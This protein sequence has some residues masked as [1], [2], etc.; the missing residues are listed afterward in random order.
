MSMGDKQVLQRLVER[1]RAEK[2]RLEAEGV[3]M[4]DVLEAVAF[5]LYSD[6]PEDGAPMSQD[7]L[8]CV[9][10]WAWHPQRLVYGVG[11][12][13]CGAATDPT[14]AARLY[15]VLVEL[16][17]PEPARQAYADADALMRDNMDDDG[18]MPPT[19]VISF[20]PDVI[21]R[22]DR[23][24]DYQAHFAADW[25]R[26][27]AF[28][29]ID[30]GRDNYL[31]L[32]CKAIRPPGAQAGSYRARP[33]VPTL[34]VYWSKPATLIRPG[35]WNRIGPG[36]YIGEC[37]YILEGSAADIFVGEVRWPR[38][39][40]PELGHYCFIGVIDAVLDRLDD[41]HTWP[42]FPDQF[43]F[44][45]FIAECN[46]AVWH[47]FNVYRSDAR[48]EFALRAVP[49]LAASYDLFA[50]YN[51]EVGESGAGGPLPPGSELTL[52]L[53]APGRETMRFP[54]EYFNGR[55]LQLLRD[56]GD[57]KE[58][59]Q[60]EWQAALELTVPPGTPARRYSLTVAQTF[61]R[62]HMQLGAVNWSV[63]M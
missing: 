63:Q 1:A 48:L 49:D 15:P 43:A 7:Q 31:Y 5:R 41:P 20:S 44:E 58:V 17:G 13:A 37:N 26:Q 60:G 29:D 12:A 28:D 9:L 35:D 57:F 36:A 33:L 62:G 39:E 16:Y 14:P 22:N 61:H 52:V 24:A 19:G 25:D 54:A 32:R 59:A 45:R 46:S 21:P 6:F 38:A 2:A 47:N 56:F 50:F 11:F 34:S 51:V 40:I 23:V 30:R 27:P 8:S 55:G 42:R 10:V 4:Q 3:P 53:R 18:V